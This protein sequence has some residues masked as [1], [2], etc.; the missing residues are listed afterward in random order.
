MRIGLGRA[1]VALCRRRVMLDRVCG[2]ARGRV[3]TRLRAL[4][5]GGTLHRTWVFDRGPVRPMTARF[6]GG[7][8]T[9]RVAHGVSLAGEAVIDGVGERGG[10]GRDE[11]RHPV[12][13]IAHPHIPGRDGLGVAFRHGTGVEPRREDVD[14]G[15][16]P[17][18]REF[19]GALQAR[20]FE[21]RP[22]MIVVDRVACGV[23]HRHV[24]AGD[25]PCFECV[26]GLG[27][28]CAQILRVVQ[29]DLHRAFTD[30]GG[31]REFGDHDPVRQFRRHA[32]NHDRA[33]AGLGP[34]ADS[35][36]LRGHHR[37]RVGEDPD[38]RRIR[39]RPRGLH[40]EET[41]DQRV[42]ARTH[43]GCALRNDLLLRADAAGIHPEGPEGT[44]V[45]REDGEREDGHQRLRGS[46]SQQGWA[47]KVL[48]L[49][50]SWAEP[51]TNK[52]ST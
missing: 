13:K 22:C 30:A 27:E 49:L 9:C 29:A 40:G 38:L 14:D 33:P 11:F 50:V 7:L 24:S 23:D 48:A 42:R 21:D 47:P 25:Q 18:R 15:A 20:R 5:C 35:S 32:R 1:H 2:L 44:V 6:P 43:S 17:T 39:R 41:I 52:N 36:L 28:P 51:L 46:A 37:G 31:D 19:C 26:D 10:E 4:S 3:V 12:G 16:E 34:A 8:G 45:L